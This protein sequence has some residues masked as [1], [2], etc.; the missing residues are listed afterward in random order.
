MASLGG[1]TRTPELQ[2]F[3]DR[4]ND[5]ILL[6]S[7][8]ESD[9]GRLQGRI[10]AALQAARPAGDAAPVRLPVCANFDQTVAKIA[11]TPATRP[12]VKA[13]ADALRAIEP[14]LVWQRRWTARPGDG[15]FYDGH[16]NA[17]IVGPEGLEIRED[18]WIGV[19][20]MAPHIDYPEHHHAPEEVY[21]ALSPG[22]WRNE[23]Q[24][25]FAPGPGG[26]VY[27]RS[28]T[29]HAM[30]AGQAPLLAVWSLW[31]GA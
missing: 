9:A 7:A 18:I 13:L 20:L 5:A 23:E 16:A 17:N 30:R 6:R 3:L 4:L 11:A 25:W 29:R 10:A 15:G 26:L 19:S 22:D 14:Q 28:D 12:E 31:V 27:N 1:M 8:P 21:V 2:N 24:D